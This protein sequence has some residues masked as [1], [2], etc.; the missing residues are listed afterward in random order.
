MKVRKTGISV[1]IIIAFISLLLVS[2]VLMGILLYNKCKGIIEKQIKE[3]A[4]NVDK[5]VAASVNGEL[6]AT[7]ETGSEGSE[8]YEMP[9]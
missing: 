1:K 8:A 6:L 2:D 9:V 5:C 7:I 3:S 4:M